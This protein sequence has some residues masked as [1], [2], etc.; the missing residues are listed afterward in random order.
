VATFN[1]T[2]TDGITSGDTPSGPSTYHQ[3]VPDLVG[4]PDSVTPFYGTFI[5]DGFVFDSGRPLKAYK[6]G[7]T[8]RDVVGLPS[9]FSVK[10]IYKPSV[11][12]TLRVRDVLTR[13]YPAALASGFSV[14]A[15]LHVA[16]AVAVL[17]RLKAGATIGS[18][19]K[20]S[21]G[22]SDQL[23]M[24][25]LA[26]WYLG[27]FITDGIGLHATQSQQAIYERAISSLFGMTDLPSR[28]FVTQATLADGLDLTDEQVLHAIFHKELW[29]DI[30]FACSY[31]D[32]DGDVTTWAINTRTSGVTEYTNFNFNSFAKIGNKYIA[33]SSEGLF[34][35]NGPLDVS[36][37]IPAQVAGGFLQL[38]G[39]RFTSFTE[40]YLGLNTKDGAK[41]WL[42]KLT[43]GE[44]LEYV[45]RLQPNVGMRTTKVQFGKGLRARYFAW[46][47]CS[48]G[49]DFD[50]DTIE[51]VPLVAKRRV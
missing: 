24:S 18:S 47:L 50:L 37:A 13:L 33:A 19:F 8:I 38:G 36:A 6:A 30:D 21:Q 23:L 4:F 31:F 17:E 15:A 2:V 12:D 3:T 39:S 9:T 48:T 32:I 34:E 26:V 5:T 44:G 29:D 43:T 20:W 49:A 42:L 40:A 51:F 10:S 25:P 35:L 28:L 41:D 14:S 1:V 16:Q 45:Y 7:A 46:E 11:T 27:G 22:V